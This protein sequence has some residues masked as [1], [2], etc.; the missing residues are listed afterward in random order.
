L[1]QSPPRIYE[2]VS[3]YWSG[4]P[5]SYHT[6][7]RFYINSSFEDNINL[8]FVLII[9]LVLMFFIILFW[10][11]IIKHNINKLVINLKLIRFNTLFTKTFTNIT[12]NFYW[13]DFILFPYFIFIFM[14]LFIIFSNIIYLL[15]FKIIYYLFR[16]I[17]IKV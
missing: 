12:N 11:L 13:F 9:L 14:G 5:P 6:V 4:N 15:S 17:F 7:D 3:S 10:K 1:L 16:V 8:D 2:R